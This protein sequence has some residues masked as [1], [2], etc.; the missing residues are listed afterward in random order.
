MLNFV[1]K[2]YLMLNVRLFKAT[3]KLTFC[4][5]LVF[6]KEFSFYTNNFSVTL[7]S[8]SRKNPIYNDLH[9]VAIFFCS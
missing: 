8:L 5:T 4:Y 7:L 2:I 6:Q 1:N 9:I 3:L